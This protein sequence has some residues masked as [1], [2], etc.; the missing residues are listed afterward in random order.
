MINAYLKKP[1][2][3]LSSNSSEKCTYIVCGVYT[4]GKNKTLDLKR[5]AYELEEY[6][7]SLGLNTLFINYGELENVTGISNYSNHDR[8]NLKSIIPKT[9]LPRGWREDWANV[10]FMQWKPIF[11]DTINGHIS[12]N[13]TVIYIDVNTSK[14]PTYFD[15]LK[16]I[17]KYTSSLLGK[18]KI[19][20]FHDSLNH[21]CVHDIKQSAIKKSS[22][23]IKEQ[24]LS[25]WAGLIIFKSGRKATEFLKEWRTLSSRLTNLLPVDK[26][27]QNDEFIYHAQEQA[28]LTICFYKNK[29][30]CNTFL[31]FGSRRFPAL[32]GEIKY[33]I[34]DMPIIFQRKISSKR[35]VYILMLIGKSLWYNLIAL[36]TQK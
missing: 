16:N 14:Y 6:C 7:L 29:L 9:M 2:I 30:V 5:E 36:I 25:I 4:D 17:K 24:D 20:L 21:L 27:I 3:K 13:T 15:L 31:L 32:A 22:Q 26:L 28:M 35:K 12:R 23:Y 11:L 18:K 33:L 19:L 1:D 10:G 8:S 34:K